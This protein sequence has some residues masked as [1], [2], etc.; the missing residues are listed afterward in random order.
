MLKRLRTGGV[1]VITTQPDVDVRVPAAP[2]E[3]TFL[4]VPPYPAGRSLLRSADSVNDRLGG[5]PVPGEV[6]S[7]LR[8]SRGGGEPLPTGLSAAMGAELGADLSAV[9]V[10]T[11]ADSHSAVRA[12]QA[13]AFADGTDL[14]FSRGAYAPSTDSGRRLLAHEVSHVTQN[15]PT[16]S[17]APTV[18]RADDPA[19]QAADR[20]AGRIVDALR[21]STG[22]AAL[23][24]SDA[25]PVVDGP[26]TP[27]SWSPLRRSMSARS[28]SQPA[29]AHPRSGRQISPRLR[30]Q[31]ISSDL[32]NEIFEVEVDKRKAQV[33]N[34]NL[35]RARIGV[36]DPRRQKLEG[37][38]ADPINRKGTRS[39]PA[40]GPGA[41]GPRAARAEGAPN[42]TLP[43]VLVVGTD[44]TVSPRLLEQATGEHDIQAHFD[45]LTG[46]DP[47]LIPLLDPIRLEAFTAVRDLGRV[48]TRKVTHGAGQGGD[49]AKLTEKVTNVVTTFKNDAARALEHR[50]WEDTVAARNAFVA[51]KADAEMAALA[52]E[53]AKQDIALAG[54]IYDTLYEGLALDKASIA[55]LAATDSEMA[56]L[57]SHAVIPAPAWTEFLAAATRSDA[58]IAFARAHQADLA[59]LANAGAVLQVWQANTTHVTSVADA[60]TVLALPLVNH[61]ATKAVDAAALVGTPQVPDLTALTL[62]AAGGQINTIKT[63]KL[64]AELGGD[65]LATRAMRNLAE[66]P[67][68]DQIKAFYLKVGRDPAEASNSWQLL[69]AN[70]TDDLKKVQIIRSVAKVAAAQ[71][72][73]FNRLVTNWANLSDR[74]TVADGIVVQLVKAGLLIPLGH[75]YTSATWGKGAAYVFNLAGQGRLNPEWHVHFKFGAKTTVC[76]AGWKNDAEAGDPGVKSFS[77]GSGLETA[78]TGAGKWLLVKPDK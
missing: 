24:D 49:A 44:A 78:I 36:Q 5:S 48:G 64:Y 8:R 45:T 19:E 30:R 58:L 32:D 65:V 17:D 69:T 6:L 46:A 12:L 35:G 53:R 37:F 43:D 55:R 29:S 54:R 2:V 39:Y 42:T 72:V 50:Q 16:S 4:P 40:S 62:I 57:A 14:H 41:A 9:R 60:N 7:F 28:T 26:H 33:A 47:T 38:F 21:R 11:S 20:S 22:H 67:T 77:A 61:D 13:V 52:L 10:H 51:G 66:K 75:S 56:M 1:A 23:T 27:N 25:G 31:V 3:R 71:L 73:D 18:G 15:S 63:L 74:T 59:G 76:G 70:V 68:L 34:M